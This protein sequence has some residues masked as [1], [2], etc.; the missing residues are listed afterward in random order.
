M[1]SEKEPINCHRSILISKAFV[2]KNI[3]VKHILIDGNVISQKEI[4][5]MLLK[6]YNF[7]QKTQTSLDS[8]YKT[9]ESNNIHYIYKAYAKRNKEIGYYQF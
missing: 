2:D 4:E 9:K 3:A 7:P 1:C 6:L 5:E 8:F